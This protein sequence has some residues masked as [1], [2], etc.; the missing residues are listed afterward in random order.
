MPTRLAQFVK[1]CLAATATFLTSL[2]V[3][4]LLVEVVGLGYQLSYVVAFVA[5]N[6]MGYLLNAR[7]TFASTPAQRGSAALLRF[8][9]VNVILLAINSGLLR[10]MVERLHI[11][12]LLASVVLALLNAP[13]AF[14]VH[15]TVTYRLKGFRDLEQK[16]AEP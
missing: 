7:F 4:A 15:R 9:T 6:L 3:L 1:F 14:V 13:V 8:I 16:R 12:Y 11:Y 2:V 5:S 10:V